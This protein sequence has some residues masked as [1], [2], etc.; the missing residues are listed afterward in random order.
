MFNTR[1][2]TQKNIR[3]FFVQL[4]TLYSTFEK[5]I[6]SVNMN[7]FKDFKCDHNLNRKKICVV[8][9]KKNKSVIAVKENGLLFNRIKDSVH[10]NLNFNDPRYPT[11]LCQG[12]KKTLFL[13]EQGEKS[14]QDLPKDK[15]DPSQ[16]LIPSNTR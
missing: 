13:I 15:F 9:F 4:C 7:P 2:V 14:V 1:I 5:K 12:C 16:I 3:S 11:G 8:C 10:S 6:L